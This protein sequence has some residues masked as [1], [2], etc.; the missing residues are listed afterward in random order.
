VDVVDSSENCM[1]EWYPALCI[2][3]VL[4]MMMIRT[5]IMLIT[6]TAL[7]L[8]AAHHTSVLSFNHEDGFVDP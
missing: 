1:E 6:M 5:M 8:E 3:R 2:R 7:P 4:L